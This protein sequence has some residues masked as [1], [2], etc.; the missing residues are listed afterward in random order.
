[1]NTLMC[2]YS[3]L[4]KLT[5]L[6]LINALISIETNGQNILQINDA[7]VTAGEQVTINISITNAD[8]FVGF[9]LDIP[10]PAATT[11]VSNSAGLI[12]ARSNGHSFSAS[13]LSGNILRII[14]FSLNNSTF[15]GNEGPVA[16]FSLIA[17][18]NPG[19]YTLTVQNGMIA[20]TNTNIMT[21][22]IDGTLIIQSPNILVSPV[23]QDFGSIPLGS[24]TDRTFNIQN[25][26]NQLL[27]VTAI[28]INNPYFENLNNNSY[29]INPGQ[30]Q[31][32]IIRFN[33]VVKGTFNNTMTISSNDPDQPNTIINLTAIAFAVNE[34]HTDEI[35]AASGT[36]TNL[37][38]SI[39]NMENFVGFQFDLSLPTP[40]TYISGSIT[41]NPDRITDHQTSI[42]LVNTT[43]LRIVA[44]SPS[45]SPFLGSDGNIVQLRF[46]VEGTAGWYP[47]NIANVIIGDINGANITSAFTS[48]GLTITAPDI[49]ANSQLAFGDVSVDS[50]SN[51][52]LIVYNYGQEVLTISSL[53]F[54]N[55]SFSKL[56]NMPVSIQPGQS[57][58]LLVHFQPLY[59]GFVSGIMRI[60]STDPDE[61][62]FN[63]NLSAFVFYPNYLSVQN[64]TSSPGSH[65]TIEISVENYEDFV[66]FQF[67]ITLPDGIAFVENSATLAINRRQDH[68]LS[69]NQ[70]DNGA[71][72][73]LSFSLNQLPFLGND[74][75]V[76]Q[77]DVLVNESIETGNYPL[78][79]SNAF[80][81]NR[82]SNNILYDIN[83]GV[84][85]ILAQKTLD[86]KVFVEGAFDGTN[87]MSNSLNNTDLLPTVQPYNISPWNYS[88][89][90]QSTNFPP[91]IIDWILVELRDAQT[92]EDADE[93]T[94]LGSWPRAMLLDSDGSILDF[95]GTVPQIGNPEYI[96][97]LYIVIRHRNHLDVMSSAPLV[98]SG[99]TYTYDFTD[100]VT[101]A[102]GG[103]AGYK[104]LADGVFGMIAGDGDADGSVFMSDRTTWRN[105]LGLSNS[106]QASDY[107]LDG[108]SYMSDRALWRA[109][110]GVTNPLDVNAKINCYKSQ[111][112][113]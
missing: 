111:V 41:L 106:Y 98:L 46:N 32:I 104:Q 21:G 33:A 51:Q 43:T 10:L 15:N 59:A 13:L 38:F 39:N 65:A 102:Y 68:Q 47:L 74:G 85:S 24:S 50:S 103:A 75:T 105:N 9:Q 23:S 28:N 94:I 82:E 101:K 45:N 76:V 29:N 12:P 93:S 100:D 88:G 91:E 56:T 14:A 22:S 4:L 37:N 62:P 20:N 26:G 69:V 66:G 73:F 7:S 77:F 18:N 2:Q 34:L 31:S 107:D 11:Y 83:N 54:T 71:L 36:Q 64:L 3:R 58:Q 1:M 42:N 80:L 19:A 70:L 67:D 108:N 60:Y 63:V 113:K 17:G 40:L 95:N 110:L 86:V 44:F 55:S 30:S 89:T 112:P 6:L 96:H 61:N 49:H 84:L 90:E 78:T 48:G 109:N 8:P 57:T 53:T 16:Y 52:H 87:T 25:T 35:V 72:R 99:N 92:P 79:L 81:G 5:F 97:N 27:S